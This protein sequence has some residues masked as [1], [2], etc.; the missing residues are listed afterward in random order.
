MGGLNQVEHGPTQAAA[1]VAGVVKMVAGDASWGDAGDV[2]CVGLPAGGLDQQR[3]V[4][5]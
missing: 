3:G 4:S 1:R 2:A 5:D